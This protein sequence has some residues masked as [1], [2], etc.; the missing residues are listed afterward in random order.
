MIT[1]TT[2]FT[3]YPAGRKRAFAVGERPADLDPEYE[4]LLI[5]KGLAIR[6]QPAAPAQQRKEKRREAVRTED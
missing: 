1:I 3:G 6:E 4:A 5:G 2:A